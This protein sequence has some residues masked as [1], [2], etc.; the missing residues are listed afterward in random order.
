MWKVERL[1]DV[2]RDCQSYLLLKGSLGRKDKALDFDGT[3]HLFAY[4]I[5]QRM[6]KIR[7]VNEYECLSRYAMAVVLPESFE[8]NPTVV[9][10]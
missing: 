8:S 3:D 1:P 5:Y 9:L 10:T 4:V 7:Q 6:T 2:S